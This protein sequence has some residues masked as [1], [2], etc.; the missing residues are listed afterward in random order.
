MKTQKFRS[1]AFLVL[2]ISCVCLTSCRRN[3]QKLTSPFNNQVLHFQDPKACITKNLNAQS[4]F[5]RSKDSIAVVKNQSS[6]G[7][8][9]V[10]YK[11]GLNT[12]L[13]TNSHVVKGNSSVTLK[14][15]DESITQARVIADAGG[16]TPNNDLAILKTST[17]R[18]TALI[19]NQN[20]ISIGVDVVAI[21]APK[22]LEFSLT[23]GVVSSVRDKGDILQIDAPI[24][25]GNSGGPVLDNS[26]CVVGIATFVLNDSEG[27]NF[28]I[29]SKNAYQYVATN[30]FNPKPIASTPKSIPP[31]TQHPK[32][33]LS[34][35]PIKSI[36]QCWARTTSNSSPVNFN[37]SI[38]K[39]QD[40]RG[41]EIYDLSSDYLGKLSIIL[42]ADFSTQIY[43]NGER[44]DGSWELLDN[45]TILVKSGDIQFAFLVLSR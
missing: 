36:N 37:C 40:P 27:L 6:V 42:N 30:I 13:L 31:I 11:D 41:I 7:S 12:Y 5:D 44:N 34:K 19:L 16:S 25:P 9:F 23:R 26:G 28:A 18:G 17:N 2:T 43:S 15:I 1:L 35:P 39:R 8:A 14:W 29:A 45:G 3:Q 22:G 38:Q 32:L 4:I 33:G 21:G 10:V 24:N 20:P